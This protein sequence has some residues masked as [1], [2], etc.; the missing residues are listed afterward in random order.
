MHISNSMLVL[1]YTSISDFNTTFAYLSKSSFL[2]MQSEITNG[3][4][5]LPSRN[6]K[7][8]PT[9]GFID[10]TDSVGVVNMSR[11]HFI[12]G[13]GGGVF[14]VQSRTGVAELTIVNAHFEHCSALLNGGVISALSAALNI[15]HSTFINNSARS[16][17][18]LYFQCDSVA[19]C[20]SFMSFSEFH[21]NSAV[22]GGV[23][24]WT[25][26]KP[27]LLGLFAFNNMA[28][29][30]NFEASLPTH[31]ALNSDT[32]VMYGV[33]GTRMTTPIVI[34]S[35]DSLNQTVTTDNS[36]TVQLASDNIIGT[37]VLPTLNG[38][39]NFS[40]VIIETAPGSYVQIQV[41]S[42]TI[43]QAFPN[44]SHSFTFTYYTRLC[45]SGEITLALSCFLCPKNTYSLHPSDT[46]C[47]DCPSYATCPGG[48]SLILNS[49]YWR[50]S[51]LTSD[52][53]LCPNSEACAGGINSSCA[54]GYSGVL[55]SSCQQGYYLVGTV[56]CEQCE[57]VPVIVVRSCAVYII[58][59]S[60]MIYI[61]NRLNTQGARMMTVR[62]LAN[63]LHFLLILPLIPVNYS[64]TL[65]GFL[66]FN[67]MIVSFGLHSFPLDCWVSPAQVWR[68]VMTTAFPV[69][70]FLIILAIY[71]VRSSHPVVN[72][73]DSGILLLWW[74]QPYIVKT[75]INLLACKSQAGHWVLIS[76]TDVA[77]WGASHWKYLLGL[78]LPG[79]LIYCVAYPIA[80]F[81]VLSKHCHRINPCYLTS[82]LAKDSNQEAKNCVK[83]QF[84]L[85]LAALFGALDCL[86]QVLVV[87]GALY[88]LLT[89]SKHVYLE[90]AHYLLNGVGLLL[91]TYFVAASYYFVAR[92]HLNHYI[93]T[94]LSSLIFTICL[95]YILACFALMHKLITT[96]AAATLPQEPTSP[97]SLDDIHLVPQP[98][99]ASS[100]SVLSVSQQIHCD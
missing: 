16:G 54:D 58:A 53:H 30:G 2:I 45:I 11:F 29:Y 26:V 22:E 6:S 23:L 44:S 50:E 48:N 65:S 60:S 4:T 72:A 33:A 17:G 62:L 84:L 67:E 79:F 55:C 97:L 1:E 61:A 98:S 38:V 96:S 100:L 49:G 82:G 3:G 69:M 20:P 32:L 15:S 42:P 31:I 37:N 52:V 90:R 74:I 94:T 47:H 56:K 18:V 46:Y 73:V 93:L 70:Y 95:L 71:W 66:A 85:L 24:K 41:L 28:V 7:T 10:S 77:C 40:G 59:L 39:A 86:F 5:S 9:A 63:F 51:A 8:A 21:N 34:T 57:S 80:L 68:S 14:A 12:S 36:S 25:K 87:A 19:E 81:F 27:S 43:L 75:L 92:L 91:Q 83:K 78:F 88:C 64:S 76:D 13:S 99:P 89:W 35:L